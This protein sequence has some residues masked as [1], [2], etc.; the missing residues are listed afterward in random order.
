M[1][2]WRFAD[3]LPAENNKIGDDVIKNDDILR[4]L[5]DDK[6]TI[7]FWNGYWNWPFYG[8]GVGN[9]GFVANKCRYTNCYTTNL[10]K[11]LSQKNKRIDAVVVHGWDNDLSKL[12]DTKVSIIIY[13]ICDTR[14]YHSQGNSNV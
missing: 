11:K 9:T 7:L 6:L 10:R 1:C 2:N 14:A 8:M 13:N 5:Q 3:L 12:S 4:G